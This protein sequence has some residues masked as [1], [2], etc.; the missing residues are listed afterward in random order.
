MYL[1]YTVQV[2]QSRG[3]W[4]VGVALGNKSLEGARWQEIRFGQ[5]IHTILVLRREEAKY[6]QMFIGCGKRVPPTERMDIDPASFQLPSPFLLDIE[7]PAFL[8]LD[9]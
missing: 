8:D 9:Q 2:G 3:S 1:Y 7:T 6:P 5:R 4:L